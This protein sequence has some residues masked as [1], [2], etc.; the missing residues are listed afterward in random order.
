MNLK[1]EIYYKLLKK[2]R[3]DRWAKAKSITLKSDPIKIYRNLTE[4]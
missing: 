3:K 4:K 1:K 2:P